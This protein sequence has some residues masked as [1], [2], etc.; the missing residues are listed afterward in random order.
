MILIFI[1]GF[2]WIKGSI[3]NEQ[4]TNMSLGLL[5][6]KEAIYTFIVHIVYSYSEQRTRILFGIFKNVIDPK[7]VEENSSILMFGG[8]GK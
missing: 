6:Q 1:R 8:I 3:D 2:K 5:L 7:M 4:N